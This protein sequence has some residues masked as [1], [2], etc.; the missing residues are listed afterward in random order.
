M[1]FGNN[2]YIFSACQDKIHISEDLS[3]SEEQTLLVPTMLSPVSAGSFSSTNPA[4][5]WTKDL[6]NC[7][8]IMGCRICRS[9]CLSLAWYFFRV[10][11][12]LS[13]NKLQGETQTLLLTLTCTVTNV[14]LRVRL[15]QAVDDLV[16]LLLPQLSVPLH[17][18]ESLKQL[19]YPV[20]HH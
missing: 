17:P 5:T 14:H 1:K 7:F 3:V 8:F 12:K 6:P 9:S 15:L 2:A 18:F 20:L 10:R 16:L 13:L 19:G 11:S 4:P